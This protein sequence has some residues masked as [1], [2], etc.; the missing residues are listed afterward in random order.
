MAD[1]TA[2]KLAS[3]NGWWS[4]FGKKRG[5][6]PLGLRFMMTCALVDDKGRTR[7]EFNANRPNELWLTDITEHATGEG[8][9]YLCAAWDVRVQQ[10]RRLLDRVAN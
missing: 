3:E 1:R 9:L 10:D 6:N 7:C 2:W 4:A 8:K 5:K